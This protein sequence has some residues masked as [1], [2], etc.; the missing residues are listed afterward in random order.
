MRRQEPYL[1]VIY[2]EVAAFTVII[3]VSWGN[4]LFNV[5]SF[6]FGG[7]YSSNW[8]EALFESCVTTLVAIPTI[9][10]TWMIV[11]RLRYLEEFLKVCA[12]CRKVG[13]NDQ[14]YSMEEYFKT[15]HN[16]KTTHGLCPTC[17]EKMK[18]EE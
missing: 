10:M 9:L 5:A 4:E 6:L 7:N 18:N 12:W 14:W 3:C 2:V 1:R 13:V 15:Q 17:S 16:T 8:R 11:R